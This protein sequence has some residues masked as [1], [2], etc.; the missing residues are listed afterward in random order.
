M[1]LDRG[2]VVWS[3]DDLEFAGL[4]RH[5]VAGTVLVTIGVSADDDWLMPFG[6][7]SRDV[8]YDDGLSED[9]TI[10]VVSDGSVG[11]LPHLLQVELLDSGL[12]W[13]D[14][15]TF[16]ADLALTDGLCCLKGHLIIGF[17]S[18]MNTQIE[19]FNVKVQEGKD[20]LV[21]DPLP[22]DTGHLITVELGDRVD[23]FDFFELH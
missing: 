10:E 22:D 12:I 3:E 21:L 2:T 16:D 9:S 1:L 13:G 17:I 18:M 15:R 20:Q 6:D 7:D 11:T 5:E 8:L 23:D 14:G 19:V 4:S